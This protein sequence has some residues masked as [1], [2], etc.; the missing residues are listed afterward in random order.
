LITFSSKGDAWNFMWDKVKEFDLC[1][2]LSGLQIAK[3]LC[4]SH[5]SG[6]CKGACQGVEKEKKYNKRAQKAID[7]FFEQGQTVAMVGMGRRPDEKSVVL[8]E[9]GNYLGFGFFDNSE[10]ISNLEAARNFIKPSKDNRVVQNIVNSYLTNPKG[11]ELVI[12]N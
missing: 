4:F 1:P 9:N 12:F 7:S 6:S 3:G 10:N 2:K 8:V 11:V 5:Q